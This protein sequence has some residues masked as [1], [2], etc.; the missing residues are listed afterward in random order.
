MKVSFYYWGH[1]CP[2]HEAGLR[3]LERYENRLEITRTDITGQPDVA[4]TQ[5]MFFPMLTVVN[6][7]HRYFAPLRPAFLEALCRGELPPQEPYRPRLGTRVVVGTLETLTK[8]NLS[9]AVRCSGDS[10]CTARAKGAWLEKQGKAPF[11]ILNRMGDRLLGGAEFLPSA[12]V[13]YDIPKRNDTAFLTCLYGT[14]PQADYKSGP[15]RALEEMLRPQ[16]RCILAISDE[17]GVFP[18]G[19]LELFIRNGY[20]DLG[21]IHREAGYCRLHL[22]EKEL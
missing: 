15:L 12:V 21:V 22:V 2:C 9:L 14:H 3:L 19:N 8:E 17:E 20:H 10:A 4:W 1:Q 6:D 18:N 16:Y 11:G 7:K 13:P 5:G